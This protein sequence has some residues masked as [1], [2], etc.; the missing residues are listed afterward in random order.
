MAAS[1]G[2]CLGDD[3]EQGPV[4]IGE[5]G[6]ISLVAEHGELVAQD[7]DLKVLGA[8]GS[9]GESSQGG[10]EAIEKARPSRSASAAFRLV[11]PPD[12]Y[13]APTNP[14]GA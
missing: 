1:L 13:S 5:R 2:E 12:R 8:S 10:D 6:P 14:V 9:H 11:N 3:A 7:D 4:V